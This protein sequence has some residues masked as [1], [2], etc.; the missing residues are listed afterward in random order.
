MSVPGELRHMTM[1]EIALDCIKR[2]WYVFPCWPKTK[3]PMTTSGFKSASV[4]RPD[5]EAW[6][7]RTPDANVAIATG[8]SGLCVVDVD[9]GLN[10]PLDVVA[11][12]AAVC[13]PSST[14]TVRTGRRP[15]FGVQMYF[16][17][18][19][20]RTTTGYK[21]GPYKGEVRS[22][23]AYVMAAGCVHPDSGEKY[24]AYYDVGV[25]PMP[26]WV[27]KL[28]PE[29]AVFDPAT[30]VDNATADEW[31]TWLLEFAD[32]HGILCK[33]YEKRAANGWWL[34]VHCPWEYAHT[35]GAGADS[36]TVLGILDGRVV[37]ECSHGTCKAAGHNTAFFKQHLDNAD[38][39]FAKPEP[40][41][42]I[43][44]T[45]SKKKLDAPETWE[46]IGEDGEPRDWRDFFDS[47]DDLLNCPP[48]TFFIR[49]FL[50]HQSICAIAAPVA[51]RKSLIALNM[52]WALCTGN[53]LFGFLKV[54]TRPTRVLYMCP[55]MGRISVA[56]R[57]R[58]IGLA[59]ELGRMLWVRTMN[60][61]SVDISDVLKLPDEALEGSVV[62]LDTAIRFMQGDETSAKD[63]KVFSAQLF[64]LQRKLGEHGSVVILYHSPK[65]TKEAFDLTLENCLRGSGEL[66][67]AVT[68]AHGT[69][70]Q[71]IEGAQDGWDARS[72]IKHVKDRDYAGAQDFEVTCARETGLMTRVGDMG[73][74]VVLNTKKPGPKANSDGMDSAVDVLVENQLKLDNNVT[75][76]TLMSA[77][78][79]VLG[80]K[81]GKTSMTETRQRIRTKLGLPG[82]ATLTKG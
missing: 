25:E 16:S 20:P 27:A 32:W 40:G 54:E 41:G 44:I 10:G 60:S 43:Q 51:Q 23:G 69:R 66:G 71:P 13:S 12:L 81:R 9:E 22:A 45:L 28:A 36:S 6:W 18:A 62:I 82:G 1:L 75:V 76:P 2:G 29:K 4:Y 35:S 55:E 30:S 38:G 50:S 65:A 24:V 64:D 57:I 67:A 56:E 73:V 52:V 47:R 14:Y 79:S 26:E 78:Q 49:D 34:G 61:G 68:D 58:K 80:V 5:I 74:K 72:F 33:G 19:A 21:L 7:K 77:V 8:P 37:F 11:F 31:K 39:E 53:D 46:G 3:K 70:L 42:D 17:V 48:P 59:D 15:A 63:M